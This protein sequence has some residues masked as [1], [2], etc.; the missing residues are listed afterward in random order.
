[1]VTM[2]RF[3][4]LQH[5]HPECLHW[6]FMLEQGGSLATW[7]LPMPPA[8]ERVLPARL[9]ADHRSD[10][11]DYEGPVSANRGTVVRWDEGEFQWVENHRDRV[12]VDLQGR[13]IAGRVRIETTT[14]SPDELRWYLS[15]R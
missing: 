12:V 8:L 3:V 6:D 4:V 5:D 13:K 11:L 14:S 2:P 1:M 9:L 7:S 10:Y 15:S